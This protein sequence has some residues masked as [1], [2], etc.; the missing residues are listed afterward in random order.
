[1]TTTSASQETSS[2]GT[3][4]QIPKTMKMLSVA[5]AKNPMK[6]GFYG[7]FKNI[8]FQ[9]GVVVREQSDPPN[10]IY[11][12]TNKNGKHPLP[13]MLPPGVRPPKN[14]ELAKVICTVMGATDDKGAPYPILIARFFNHPNLLE[15]D[16]R[17]TIEMLENEMDPAE[18]IRKQTGNNNNVQV[19]GVLI[20]KRTHRRLRPNGTYDDNSSVT[21]YIRQD[22]DKSHVIPLVCDKHLVEAVKKQARFGDVLT[23]TG[24]YHVQIV[25]IQKQDENGRPLFLEDNTPDYELDSEGK[26]KVRYQPYIFLTDYPSPYV[27]EDLLFSDP[28]VMSYPEWIETDINDEIRK[29]AALGKMQNSPSAEADMDEVAK[30]GDS[31]VSKDEFTSS[32]KAKGA[33]LGASSEKDGGL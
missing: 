27:N 6:H 18:F 22:A 32:V 2:K 24:Q 7:G 26:A 30:K 4:S 13:I 29:R 33:K 3:G 11:L 14:G 20:G 16:T 28:K 10:Q 9:V 12:R 25:K 17:R 21:F 31:L 1:M 23:F 5:Q 8:T 19:T 15:A